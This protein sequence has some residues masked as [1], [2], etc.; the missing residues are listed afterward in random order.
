VPKY[1]ILP[2]KEDIGRRQNMD[3]TGLQ[4]AVLG[5]LVILVVAIIWFGILAV[6]TWVIAKTLKWL[7]GHTWAQRLV[8]VV[9]RK[10]Q[11]WW[12]RNR[13]EAERLWEAIYI[14][15]LDPLFFTYALFVLFNR[16]ASLTDYT[17]AHP[18]Y[19]FWQLLS[20]DM[21][22]N[23]NLYAGFMVVFF[24]W[25]LGKIWVENQRFREQ[26]TMTKILYAIAKKL[27]IAESDYKITDTKQKDISE[28]HPD[29]ESQEQ[30]K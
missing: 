29:S 7:L 20:L 28:K 25:M 22:N 1:A 3:F 5:I 8:S 16:L 12:E 14:L 9:Q 17:N 4:K 26:K 10:A 21:E 13:S 30:A 2:A 6:V 15:F 18:E 11:L 27:G 23:M 19:N 24:I